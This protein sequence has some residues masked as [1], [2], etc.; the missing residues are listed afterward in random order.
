MDTL[1]HFLVKIKYV[2]NV[3]KFVIFGKCFVGNAFDPGDILMQIGGKAVLWRGFLLCFLF[4]FYTLGRHLSW[5]LWR[6]SFGSNNLPG[7]LLLGVSTSCIVEFCLDL[8]LVPV[9]SISIRLLLLLRLFFSKK[10]LFSI[11]CFRILFFF[12]VCVLHGCVPEL[13]WLLCLNHF[14]ATGGVGVKHHVYWT[15]TCSSSILDKNLPFPIGCQVTY[16]KRSLRDWCH[17]PYNVIVYVLIA[18]YSDR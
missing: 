17:T 7:V 1:K 4:W 6:F 12:H 18:K 5:L 3:T 11:V 13:H 2:F 16:L 14:Y 10:L 8:V 15:Q 9:E